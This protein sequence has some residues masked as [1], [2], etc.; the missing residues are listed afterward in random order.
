MLL[1]DEGKYAYVDGYAP[2]PT[3]PWTTVN[4]EPLAPPAEIKVNRE[5]AWDEVMG[6]SIKLV[7]SWPA[8]EGANRYLLEGRSPT[9]NMEILQD[10]GRQSYTIENV[11]EGTYIFTVKSLNIA[12]AS[13]QPRVKTYTFSYDDETSDLAPAPVFEGLF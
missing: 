9:G 2:P 7:L 6:T 4:Q 13:G 11:I 1:I 12:G 3:L 5:V 10:S 8:V